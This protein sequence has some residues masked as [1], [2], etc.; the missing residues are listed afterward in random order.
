[1]QIVGTTEFRT[2]LFKQLALA[3]YEPN[4]LAELLDLGN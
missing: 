2:A 1:M 4:L 3:N